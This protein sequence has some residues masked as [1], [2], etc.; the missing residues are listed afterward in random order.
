MA[1]Q[2]SYS[3]Q[4]DE[5]FSQ[6]M[7]EWPLMASNYD[8]LGQIRTKILDYP[9]FYL[10]VQ[11]NPARIKSSSA[12]VD[13][14]TILNR[15]CFLCDKNRP[16]EQRSIQFMNKYQI[17]VNPFP[18]FPKHLTIIKTEHLPQQIRPDFSVLL[19]LARALPG[20]TI[21][22]NGPRSGASAPDH[23]HLQAGSKN[24]MPLDYQLEMIK[25]EY[26]KLINTGNCKTWKID[27]MIRK[28]FVI[29]SENAGDIEK[30][31]NQIC[32]KLVSKKPLEDEPDLNLHCSFDKNTWRLVVFPRSA[33][34]PSQYFADDDENILFSPAS[35]DLGGLLI[36]PRG[37]DFEKLDKIKAWSMLRQV[38]WPANDYNALN[39]LIKDS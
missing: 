33:H 36:I 11:F 30:R 24:T 32:E 5:L 23:F 1:N 37:E 28:F 22:Y 39:F 27:D 14:T 26:G 34:R 17:M 35:V 4:V 21:F 13:K 16:V 3:Q 19:E 9:D 7:I 25:S 2:Y 8:A 18:I 29:E 12:K 10:K 31:F 38:C 6:Q 20:F 15:I